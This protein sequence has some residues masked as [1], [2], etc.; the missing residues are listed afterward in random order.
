MGATFLLL[1]CLLKEVALVFSRRLR[2]LE[3][4]NALREEDMDE[5]EL[6]LEEAVTKLSY[7]DWVALHE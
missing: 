2:L 5:R 4:L 1:F 7:F 6:Q 3:T